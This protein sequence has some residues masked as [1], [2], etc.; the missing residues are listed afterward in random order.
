MTQYEKDKQHITDLERQLAEEHGGIVLPDRIINEAAKYKF[1]AIVGPL[2]QK[3]A[4]LERQLA[5]E[6]AKMA[7][8]VDALRKLRDYNRDIAAV[9]INYRPEDH[10][11][12]AEEAIQQDSSTTTLADIRREAYEECAVQLEETGRQYNRFAESAKR[13]HCFDM[14]DSREWT[15]QRFFEQAAAIRRKANEL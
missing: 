1:A 13:E 15:A 7:V 10:I 4:D 8:A 12:V 9:R 5:E 3:L 11:Q 14:G 2:E 6:R